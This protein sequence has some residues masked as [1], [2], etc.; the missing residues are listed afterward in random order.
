M[1][2]GLDKI[3]F[4]TKSIMIT[5]KQKETIECLLNQLHDWGEHQ[6]DDIKYWNLSKKM[7]SGLISILI[8]RLEFINNYNEYDSYYGGDM[9]TDGFKD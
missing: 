5:D 7:A 1:D 2:N 8:D 9:Y 6:Y 3:V 4:S